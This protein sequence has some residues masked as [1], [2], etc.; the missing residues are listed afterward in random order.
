MAISTG[1]AIN[2]TFFHPRRRCSRAYAV[3]SRGGRFGALSPHRRRRIRSCCGRGPSMSVAASAGARLR[4]SRPFFATGAS[5]ASRM[6]RA[7]PPSSGECDVGMPDPA[8]PPLRA[9]RAGVGRAV[10]T[11]RALDPRCRSSSKRRFGCPDAR[12][13]RPRL[14]AYHRSRYRELRRS[15]PGALHDERAGGSGRP[16]HPCRRQITSSS[17]FP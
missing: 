3:A 15:G 7:H 2:D 12:A 17:R 16:V 11:P 5:S 6:L 13:D 8:A 1:S 14:P 10:S 9:R 4:R